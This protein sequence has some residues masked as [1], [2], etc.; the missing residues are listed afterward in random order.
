MLPKT[1]PKLRAIPERSWGIFHPKIRPKTKQ[2]NNRF[3]GEEGDEKW[4]GL[5][6]EFRANFGDVFGAKKT[7][8][9][10]G[11]KRPIFGAKMGHF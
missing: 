5:G 2:E 9:N 7:P 4:M 6:S 11:E 3:G 1:G 8:Q 10:R